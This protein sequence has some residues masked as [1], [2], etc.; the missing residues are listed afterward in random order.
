MSP[1]TRIR[2]VATCIV[3]FAQFSWAAE[4]V[5]PPAPPVQLAHNVPTPIA[6][7]ALLTI[8]GTATPEALQ[9]NI[10][11][12]S[13]KS[14]VSGD[15]VSVTV[16]GKSETVTRATGGAYE[17]PI[18]GLR[19]DNVG[20]DVEIIVGHDGI[21]EILT[22]KVSTA[23]EASSAGGLLRDHKQVAWW[24]LNI[25]IVLIAAIAISR[26]KG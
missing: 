13:D 25:V 14:L 4:P 20:K 22:A 2:Q 26:R 17:V 11:R 7:S 19:G 23:A 9:L 1:R 15:D 16:D 5:A 10:R 3:L 8:D 6:H 18:D 12:I 24:I 21:R